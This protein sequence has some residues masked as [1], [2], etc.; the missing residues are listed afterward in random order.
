MKYWDMIKIPKQYNAYVEQHLSNDANQQQPMQS[1]Q[2]DSA[3]MQNQPV[4]SAPSDIE[5][6]S[7]DDSQI[8]MLTS[9]LLEYKEKYFSDIPLMDELQKS[10]AWNIPKDVFKVAERVWTLGEPD[11]LN[12]IYWF[13]M[14]CID[15]CVESI[16]KFILIAYNA[17]KDD[18][19]DKVES[20]ADD[21]DEMMNDESVNDD[22]DDDIVSF[23]E[24]PDEENNNEGVNENE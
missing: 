22:N 15:P 23:I 4:V 21:Y 1:N 6:T 11:C 16:A 20:L 7:L 5:N 8:S 17:M 18:D 13:Y 19:F 10:F 24:M 3:L 12:P 2:I 14:F 9:M